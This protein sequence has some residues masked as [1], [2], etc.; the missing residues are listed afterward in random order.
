MKKINSLIMRKRFF[1]FVLLFL[2]TFLMNLFLWNETTQLIR[3]MP[4]LVSLKEKSADDVYEL[5]FQPSADEHNVIQPYSQSEQDRILQFLENSFFDSDGKPNL[6][7][8][9]QSYLSDSSAK[10]DKEN[11]TPVTKEMLN[12][13]IRKDFIDATFMND[14]LI[15]NIEKSVTNDI[16]KSAETLDFRIGLNSLNEKFREEF[17]YYFGNFI[18]GLALSLVFMSFGLLIVYWIIS[19]SLKIFQQ[20]IRLHRVM[21]LT[22]R[23]ITNNFK[24]LLML[25]VNVS[26]MVFLV[27]AY[28][29]GFHI[30]PVDYLYLLLLNSSLLIISNLI[31]KKK[32]GRILDA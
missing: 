6:Y 18:F 24:L 17:N 13:E 1:L 10:M 3:Q 29:T 32:M 27:F 19:S 21:G 28:S 2:T 12:S 31:I 15:L 22:N 23:K 25:P 5:H 8:G 14:I 7:S 4:L 9:K 11:L 16:E 30:L 26:F 20:D